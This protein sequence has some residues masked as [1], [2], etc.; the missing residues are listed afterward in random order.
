MGVCE[1]GGREEDCCR[2]EDCACEAEKKLRIS[3]L[4]GGMM[5]CGFW[6][7]LELR[8]VFELNVGA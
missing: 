5:S 6:N 7:D 1:A 2:C 3:A 8:V 4:R